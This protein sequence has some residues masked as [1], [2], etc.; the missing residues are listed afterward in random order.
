MGE[1]QHFDVIEGVYDLGTTMARR[2]FRLSYY[3]FLILFACRE[4]P[5]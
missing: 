1:T 4:P 2:Y 5:L 3:L